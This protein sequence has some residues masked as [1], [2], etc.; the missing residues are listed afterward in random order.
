MF[1]IKLKKVRW[2]IIC[3]GAHESKQNSKSQIS[4]KTASLSKRFKAPTLSP[5]SLQ[6][7]GSQN[8]WLISK[9][10]LNISPRNEDPS[11]VSMFKNLSKKGRLSDVIKFIGNILP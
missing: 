1:S 6:K 3:I 5:S 4:A 9:N 2:G 10:L 8:K 7:K 11:M